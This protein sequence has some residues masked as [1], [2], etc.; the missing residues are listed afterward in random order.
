VGCLGSVDKVM[1]VYW[2]PNLGVTNVT[3]HLLLLWK[4]K[5]LV[6]GVVKLADKLLWHS[7]VLD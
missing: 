5:E 1:A 6:S 2:I 3:I 7:M 4:S